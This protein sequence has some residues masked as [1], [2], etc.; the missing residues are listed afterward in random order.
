MGLVYSPSESE[1]LVNALRSNNTTAQSMIDDL[2]S[3]SRHLVDAVN[4]RT[5]SGAAYTAGKGLFTELVIPTI[6]KATSTLEQLRT[7][8]SQY[9]GY[10]GAAGGELLDED[11][12]NQ[13]LELLRA[14][15]SSMASQINFYRMQ[16]YLYPENAEMN[17]MYSN[18]Q[19]QLSSYMGT[20]ADDI[21]KVQDKLKKLHEFNSHVNGL[22]SDGLDEFK[23]ILQIMAAITIDTAGN[24]I[25]K[26]N[27]NKDFK[28]FKDLARSGGLPKE[29]AK[30]VLSQ[31]VVSKAIK[32]VGQG[33][34]KSGIIKSAL[35]DGETR[36]G[37]SAR[38]TKKFGDDIVDVGKGVGKSKLF[39]TAGVIG[40]VLDVGL[41]YDEQMSKYNDV[42]RAVKNTGAHL[43]IGMAGSVAGT[44]FGSV[45]AGYLAGSQVG[46]AIGTLIPIPVVGTVVGAVVGAGI[47]YLGNKAY[48]WVESGEA[49]KFVDKTVK[50]IS[51]GV[52]SLKNKAGEI[53]SGFGKS[54]GSAFG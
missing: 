13:Q 22:F 24:Y 49:G 26:F 15:Q 47:G 4:G 43:G 39:K 36:I 3:A 1:G 28:K 34:R 9:E 23:T 54:L 25:L 11:K 32:Q 7:K 21:Q 19:S 48:D 12:L 31:G 5:L 14:Q 53:F 18:F 41:D 44:A 42:G 50:N 29:I 17:L 35:T 10:A 40:T 52:N 33:Y 2:N 45:A 27:N 20:T 51:K 6:S 37:R 46:A 8:L 30:S 16:S 38:M